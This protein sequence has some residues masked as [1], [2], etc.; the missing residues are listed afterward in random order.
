MPVEEMM[1]I[2]RDKIEQKIPVEKLTW[3]REV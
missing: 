3:K 2:L 1:E